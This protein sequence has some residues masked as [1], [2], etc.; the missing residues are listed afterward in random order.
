MWYLCSAQT[1]FLVVVV[2]EVIICIKKLIY[3]VL[4][5]TSTLEM[6]VIMLLGPLV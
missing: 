6:S 3:K 2:V 4:M 5:L 1:S